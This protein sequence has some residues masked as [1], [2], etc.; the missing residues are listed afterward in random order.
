MSRIESP[1][2][3]NTFKQCPRKYYYRYKEELPSLPSIHLVRGKIVHSV[4][5][6][7]FEIDDKIRT[8]EALRLHLFWLF[9]KTWT[10]N[11]GELLEVNLDDK[12]IESFKVESK[13]M[14]THWFNRFRTKMNNKIGAGQNFEEAFQV[15]TPIRE[16]ELTSQ[17]FEIRGFADAIFES[18]GSVIILDYKT[19]KKKEITEEYQLQLGMY[20]LMYEEMFNK[21]ADVVGID[22]LTY[23]EILVPVS[24]KM[25]ENAKKEVTYIHSKT[26]S[27]KKEDYEIKPSPLCKWSSGQCDYY[28]KCFPGSN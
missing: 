2:S 3:I 23:P 17:A 27:N 6:N 20:A 25:V 19:S 13:E 10:E 24:T 28:D 18:N 9:D 7:F 21:K 8:E 11:Y 16:R 26:K 4:L 12:K 5:E 22:F 15:L 14:L 1:S